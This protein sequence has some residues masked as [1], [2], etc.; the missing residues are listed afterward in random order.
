MTKGRLGIFVHRAAGG[1]HLDI[2][3]RALQTV[4]RSL[5]LKGSM[6]E[7]IRMGGGHA[8]LTG[9]ACF[10]LQV[11]EYGLLAYVGQGAGGAVYL[12][13]GAGAGL[14]TWLKISDCIQALATE[15]TLCIVHCICIVLLIL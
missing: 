3:S 6:K 1:N 14:L 4:L 10:D 11:V 7:A 8:R 9:H 15:E 5:L 12:W 2:C 13:R